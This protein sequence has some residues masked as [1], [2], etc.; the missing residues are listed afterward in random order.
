MK[1]VYLSEVEF[2]SSLSPEDKITQQINCWIENGHDVTAISINTLSLYNLKDKVSKKHK[3]ILNR[4]GKLFTFLNHYY[5]TF[6]LYNVLTRL[7]PDIIYSRYLQYTPF[8]STLVRKYPFVFE[9]NSNDLTEYRA[10]SKITYLYNRFTRKLILANVT[11]YVCVTNELLNQFSIFSKPSVCITNGVNV[12]DYPFVADTRNA[13]PKVVFIGSPDAKWHGIEK[14]ELMAREIKDAEFHIIGII[15]KNKNNLKY[16]DYMPSDKAREFIKTCDVGIST[17]SL[18][19]KNMEEACPL[20]SRQY[21]AQA[22]PLIYA[23]NDPDLHSEEFALQI[24]NSETNVH[25]SL[26]EIRKFIF[27]VF[28]DKKLRLKC[29]NFAE[30]H[31]DVSVKESHRIDFLMNILGKQF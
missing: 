20:K 15:G 19:E 17:L 23:Y 29:R 31:I 1:I 4:P 2:D 24:P 8:L 22:I 13:I 12:N 21:L 16:H 26:P 3:S 28:G 30:Q 10:K 25:D 27:H 6:S 5:I 9:I 11:G 7:K 14:I 18:H